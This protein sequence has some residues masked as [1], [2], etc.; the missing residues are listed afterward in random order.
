MYGDIK[1]DFANANLIAAAPDLYEALDGML[2]LAVAANASDRIICHE[3]RAA[4]AK[5]R[6]E[7]Q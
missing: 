5:A 2:R 7:K 3:A 4:L 1:T 6:G